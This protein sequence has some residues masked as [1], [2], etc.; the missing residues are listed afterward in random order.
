MLGC[1]GRGAGRRAVASLAAAEPVD[2][3]PL[4]CEV[5]KTGKTLGTRSRP[6]APQ[7]V[8]EWE[9]L[10]SF[11][12]EARVDCV[13]LDGVGTVEAEVNAVVGCLRGG[14]DEF[15]CQLP[16]AELPRSDGWLEGCEEFNNGLAL[17]DIDEGFLDCDPGWPSCGAGLLRGTVKN[18]VWT[19]AE[20]ESTMLSSH[21]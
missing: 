13:M 14:S 17:D 15:R 20:V 8:R 12:F 2:G 21:T 4:W 19:V 10:Q 16:N 6:C 1:E 11:L 7:E 18:C 9:H 3:E 5:T